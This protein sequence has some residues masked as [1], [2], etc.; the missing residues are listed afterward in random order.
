VALLVPVDLPVPPGRA[1]PVALLVLAGPSWLRRSF[2]TVLLQSVMVRQRD[3]RDGDNRDER[4]APEELVEAGQGARL[5]EPTAS[6][7]LTLSPA[8]QITIKI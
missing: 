8:K 1:V 7:R 3:R 5:Y 2:L 4:D 6:P